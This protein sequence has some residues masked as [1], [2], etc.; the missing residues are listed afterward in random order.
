[1]KSLKTRISAII[2]W[3]LYGKLSRKITTVFLLFI[4]SSVTLSY[5]LYKYNAA[6]YALTNIKQSTKQTLVS[7]SQNIS[8]MIES[9]DNN[10]SLL[11][12]T[13]IAALSSGRL[14]ADT[15]RFYDTYLFTIV[16]TY[17]QISSIYFTDFSN[18][19]YGVDKSGK[20]PLQISSLSE[21]TWYED[22][23]QAKG[24]YI[25]RHNAGGIFGVPTSGF[26]SMIR[27][28]NNL[29]TQMPLGFA[30]LNIPDSYI[31]SL[32]Q[33]VFPSKDAD[34]TL[35]SENNAAMIYSGDALSKEVTA[36]VFEHVNKQ[37]TYYSYQDKDSLIAGLY[38]DNLGYT[39]VVNIPINYSHNF[40]NPLFGNWIL[41]LLINIVLMFLCSLLLSKSI[42]NPIHNL[43]HSM[44]GIKEK[45]FG[46]VEVVHPDSEIGMLED[47]YNHMILEI[48]SLLDRLLTEQR[49][50]RKIAL[51]VLQ[52]QIKP[53]FLYNTLDAIGCIALTDEPVK[54]YEAIETLGSFYRRSLGKG[55]E[56]LSLREEVEIVKDY[57]SLLSLRYES[58]FDIVYE[59]DTTLLNM[60]I[61]K[62]VLQPFIENS[63]YHGIKPLGEKGYIILS[64]YKSDSNVFIRIKDN[65]VGMSAPKINAIKKAL[66]THSTTSGIG[67]IGTLERFS[68]FY[69]EQCIYEIQSEKMWEVPL[70]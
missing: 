34:I 54:V 67:L 53:H 70:L 50:K 4:I 32:F 63:I 59:I 26:L 22:A 11:L 29:E 40:S 5:M 27:V 58:L 42:A 47:N 39:L 60:Q 44:R 3:S 13:D 69:G 35:F 24:G 31:T 66:E 49:L 61:P 33:A 68:L 16:D 46:P 8:N 25:L 15:L 7:V 20:K 21:A 10:Y 6:N 17:D 12:K 36:S 18:Y 30:I 37:N 9:T 43:I 48:E 23:L 45:D 62:L 52:E 1:M 65:G 38:M 19:L 41:L 51:N 2:S 14:D 56:I 28:V 64:I 55:Q 57:I